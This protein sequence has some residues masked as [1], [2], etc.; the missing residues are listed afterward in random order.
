MSKSKSPDFGKE[1]NFDSPLVPT[2]RHILETTPLPWIQ[3][4]VELSYCLAAALVGCEDSDQRRHVGGNLAE[5][6]IGVAMT[7]EMPEEYRPSSKAPGG[8]TH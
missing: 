3:V 6:I 8:V 1:W 5:G 4:I 7:G 2:V